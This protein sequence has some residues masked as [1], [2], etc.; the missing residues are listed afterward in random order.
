MKYGLNIRE[1]G[2]LDFLAL[3]ALVH[4]LGSGHYSLSQGDSSA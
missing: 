1:G 2:E 3:G 4:R